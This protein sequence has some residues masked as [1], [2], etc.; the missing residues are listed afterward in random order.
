MPAELNGYSWSETNKY[1][2]TY[3]NRHSDVAYIT[4]DNVGF[5][6]YQS[7]Q[8]N[9]SICFKVTLEQAQAIVEQWIKDNVP[10]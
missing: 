2:W 5:W 4:K 9:H 10:S 6:G 3:G 7:G 8:P 1:T